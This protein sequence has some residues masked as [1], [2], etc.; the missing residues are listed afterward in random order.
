MQRCIHRCKDVF[1]DVMMYSHMQRCIHICKDVFTDVR[2][3]SQMQRCIHRR[4]ESFTGDRCKDVFTDVTMCTDKRI[5]LPQRVFLSLFPLSFHIILIFSSLCFLSRSL[6]NT[7]NTNEHAYAGQLN[8]YTHLRAL[9]VLHVRGFQQSLSL[10]LFD[11]L[12]CWVF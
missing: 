3:Y 1:S 11:A 4:N 6:F 7:I 12:S 10:I 2:T 5:F 8:S 9:L